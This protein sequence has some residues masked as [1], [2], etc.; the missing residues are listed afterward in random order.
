M[1]DVDF[2][3]LT[4]VMFVKL[5][6]CGLLYFSTF[7]TIIKLFQLCHLGAKFVDP[8]FFMTYGEGFNYFLFAC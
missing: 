4:E 5:L 6:H 3:H 2:D 8:S 7:H 1:T